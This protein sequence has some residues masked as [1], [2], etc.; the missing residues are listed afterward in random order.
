MVC[1]SVLYYSILKYSIVCY[2][3]SLSAT[4]SEVRSGGPVLTWGARWPAGK[5]LDLSRILIN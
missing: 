5:L 4:R 1:Y 2:A 3:A